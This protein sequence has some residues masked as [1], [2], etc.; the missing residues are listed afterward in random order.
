MDKI[1]SQMISSAYKALVNAYAPYSHFR[2]ASTIY[3]AQGN[4][5]TGVNVEN[6][7]YGLT[8][9][10]EASAICQMV[11]SGEQSIKSIVILADN[12]LLCSPCGACRQRIHE[13]ADTHT[14]IHL[15]NKDS[16]FHT[17]TIDNVLPLA[18]DF[19][20]KPE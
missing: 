11:S 9:C 15:C 16:I 20:F 5:Y 17:L 8:I 13:F 14:Q 7:S 12:N 3:T 10:A 6:S 2:V 18:F 19:D 4:F 1:T